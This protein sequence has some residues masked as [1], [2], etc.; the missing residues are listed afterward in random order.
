MTQRNALLLLSML[1]SGCYLSHTLG[2]GGAPRDGAPMGSRDARPVDAGLGSPLDIDAFVSVCEVAS[3]SEWIVPAATLGG[4]FTT[5]V[6]IGMRFESGG[7]A[8][9]PRPYDSDGRVGAELCSC[10][11]GCDCLPPSYE[12]TV[13]HTEVA[14]ITTF[15]PVAPNG[16]IGPTIEVVGWGIPCSPIS[17]PADLVEI[18]IPDGVATPAR[19]VGVWARVEGRHFRCSDRVVPL[20]ATRGAV[21]PPVFVVEDCNPDLDPCGP[22]T[23]TP[24]ETHAFLGFFE[25]GVHRVLAFGHDVE[26]VVP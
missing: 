17:E 10:C 23:E 18:V 9:T 19:P 12:V 2:D 8:C 22:I 11:M 20:V 26:F 5:E 16:S 24:Y 6:P 7:C 15:T 4:E 14:G 13:I 3:P 25:P 21:L 1:S